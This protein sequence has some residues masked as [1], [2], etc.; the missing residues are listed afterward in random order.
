MAV[1]LNQLIFLVLLPALAILHAFFSFLM[2][3]GFFFFLLNSD[4]TWRQ[5]PP[6]MAFCQN[7]NLHPPVDAG[8]SN[9]NLD[10]PSTNVIFWFE[11]TPV[12]RGP[13]FGARR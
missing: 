2:K 7:F 11:D 4:D 1:M 8:S 9:F 12:W 13:E 5:A 6:W 3:G 10:P